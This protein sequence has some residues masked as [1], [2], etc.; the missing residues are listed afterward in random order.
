MTPAHMLDS[1]TESFPPQVRK[2]KL[3]NYIRCEHCGAEFSDLNSWANHYFFCQ[4]PP[5]YGMEELRAEVLARDRYRCKRCGK[6][7]NQHSLQVHHI[8][9]LSEGGPNEKWNL[10][11]VCR[12]CHA[13]IQP[14][15]APIILKKT[16]AELEE[17]GIR[18]PR[19]VKGRKGSVIEQIPEIASKTA[20]RLIQVLND[21]KEEEKGSLS[22]SLPLNVGVR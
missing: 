20:E 7:G 9:P 10:I 6:L 18:H 19:K 2:R 17:I 3:W 5:R 8:T 4:P 14:E 13:E 11:T 15:H 1:P 12:R 21:T 16:W 22:P